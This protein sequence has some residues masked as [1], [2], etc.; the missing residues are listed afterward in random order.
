MKCFNSVQKIY[1]IIINGIASISSGIPET[2]RSL[3]KRASVDI[4]L[5]IGV[6]KYCSRDIKMITHFYEWSL[7]L[8]S[9]ILVMFVIAGIEKK[10]Y[11]VNED[12]NKTFWAGWLLCFFWMLG[13]SFIHPVEDVYFV[14]AL[15]SLLL[16]PLLYIVWGQNDGMKAMFDMV[17]VRTV[18][19][20]YIFILLSI[21]IV[22]FINKE[23]VM[24]TTDYLGL[25]GNPN[26]NGMLSTGFYAAALYM[27]FSD[28]K[29]PFIYLLLMGICIS[30]SVISVTRASVLAIIMESA[31]AVIYLFSRKSRN[32]RTGKLLI[33]ILV[34]VVIM[35]II[36]VAAGLVLKII[37]NACLS[38]YAEAEDATAEEQVQKLDHLSSGRVEIWREYIKRSTFFGNGW[39]VEPVI[40][41]RHDS[42]WAH[43][44]IVEI[45]YISGVPACVGYI[46]W[47]GACLVFI[48][49]SIFDRNGFRMER[50]F[51]MLAISGYFAEAMLEVTIFPMTTGLAF[52]AL[53]GMIP[54]ANSGREAF[55]FK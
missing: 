41:G 30:L 33:Q 25:A 55:N 29:R 4:L 54:V 16:F 26:H 13:M 15:L 17:A 47:L 12:I 27:L 48:I 21:I 18:A 43:N 19:V 37:D 50:L 23:Q 3:V 11:T 38:V 32:N 9:L 36:A 14:W 39:S 22:P 6:L 28:K 49:R 35:T 24:V 1:I 40:E 7:I 42:R 53:L 44:T 31:A 34:A 2:A 51:S 45:L 5:L 46:I 20:A 52:L 8:G 10:E